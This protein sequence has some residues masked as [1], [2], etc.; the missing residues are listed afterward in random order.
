MITFKTLS[1]EELKNGYSTRLGFVFQSGIRSSDNS[2]E[3]LCNTLIQHN[4]TNEYPEFVVRLNDTTTA[5]VYNDNFDGPCFF[6]YANIATQVGI[7]RVE[8][9]Y[10]FLNN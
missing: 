7:C 8:S 6:Y 10:N 3:H 5:F 4:I 1:V 2:I 9:L